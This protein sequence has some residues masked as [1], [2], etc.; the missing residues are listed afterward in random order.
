MA[1]TD[2][3]DPNGLDTIDRL[4]ARLGRYPTAEELSRELLTARIQRGHST[5]NVGRRRPARVLAIAGVSGSLLIGILFFVGQQLDVQ[6]LVSP[7]VTA[8]ALPPSPAIET[9]PALPAVVAPEPLPVVE[10]PAIETPARTT[11]RRRAR[12]AAPAPT[13]ASN[14]PASPRVDDA[15]IQQRVLPE[16]PASAR[17]TI[18]GTVRINVRVS[19][20]RSGHVTEARSASPD[21]SK[22]F[23]GLAE[24]AAREWKFAS[25]APDRP[26]AAR[27]WVLR[28]DLGRQATTA[29]AVPSVP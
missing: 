15:A 11:T 27:E 14:P 21:A 24:K 6:Q 22:Y 29:A 20:D 13:P 4:K 5:E 1:R 10:I 19:V 16:I 23:A 25:A 8:P 3:P 17:R 28:F 12:A 18:T 7:D 26:D 2:A 9:T